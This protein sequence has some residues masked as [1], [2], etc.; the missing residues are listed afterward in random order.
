ME[1]RPDF[2]FDPGPR[3]I[4]AVQPSLLPTSF[5]ELGFLENLQGTWLGQGFNV[6]WRPFHGIPT[7]QDHFLEL[8]WE[9]RPCFPGSFPIQ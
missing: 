4:G 6:I 3:T 5:N 2:A 8:N 7:T 1:L 9:A